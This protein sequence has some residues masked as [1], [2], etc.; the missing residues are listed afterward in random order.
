MATRKFS[1]GDSVRFLNETGGGV[2]SGIIS[3][4][5][6][7]VSVED[8][9]EFEYDTDQLVLVNPKNKNGAPEVVI[10]KPKATP[11]NHVITGKEGLF[12]A[13]TKE[14]DVEN[15]LHHT[16]MVNN[17]N[18]IVL[19]S[20]NIIHRKDIIG[21]NSGVIIPL[22]KHLIHVAHQ[23]EIDEW[24][25]VLV[26]AVFYQKGFYKPLEPVSKRIDLGLSSFTRLKNY[27]KI[28]LMDKE[29]FIFNVYLKEEVKKEEVK[30][31][32]TPQKP[33]RIGEKTNLQ[34]ERKEVNEF[35]GITSME[36][37][38]HIEELVED[39]RGMSN[40]EIIQIQLKHF[41]KKL[42]EAIAK[43]MRSIVF[44]HG[45]GKGVLKNEIIFIL[46]GMPELTYSDA[47]MAKYGGGA[48]E[49]FLF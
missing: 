23:K 7:L 6:V 2:V 8:D 47:S 22:S 37:D 45:V 35:T 14:E 46:K 26:D 38:L 27:K 15:P 20:F 21:I 39:I 17:S 31:V 3:N 11:F 28:N 16:Y 18:F 34:K 25:G 40:G 33:F 4:E 32:V 10:N 13:V 41:Q 12:L 24:N 43:K 36:V 9:F 49:V 5:L 29:A 48:T 1:I 30:K 44:I 19:Y 42:D